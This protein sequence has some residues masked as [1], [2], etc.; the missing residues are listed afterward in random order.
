[1]TTTPHS[2]GADRFLVTDPHLIRT[3]AREDGATYW[4]TS[5]G[6]RFAV[7]PSAALLLEQLRTPTAQ[8]ALVGPQAPPEFL[9]KET[10]RHHSLL[11]QLHD[12]E[13]IISSTEGIEP[14]AGALCPT[15]RVR[16][17]PRTT[18]TAAALVEKESDG[19]VRARDPS[20]GTHCPSGKFGTAA[21]ASRRPHR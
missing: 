2:K 18:L 19:P 15:P 12:L 17:D 21:G 6:K 9:V 3:A 1:M 16:P 13:L 4:N 14:L 10:S 20:A 8:K 7:G 11:D 5:N